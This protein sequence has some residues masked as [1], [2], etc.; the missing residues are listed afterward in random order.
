MAGFQIRRVQDGLDPEDWKP[1]PSLGAG[2]REIRIH[3]LLE[4]RVIYVAKFEEGIYVLHT[5]EKRSRKTRIQ[6]LDLAKTRLSQLL[7]IRRN[8]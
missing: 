5:F 3:T 1:I 8:P 6:D 2:V 7:Q 4:H